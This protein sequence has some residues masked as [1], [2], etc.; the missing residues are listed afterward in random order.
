MATVSLITVYFYLTI[1]HMHTASVIHKK[2]TLK[3]QTH[4]Q[5]NLVPLQLERLKL[6]NCIVKDTM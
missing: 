6:C 2:Q 1:S 5:T 3:M 4:Y